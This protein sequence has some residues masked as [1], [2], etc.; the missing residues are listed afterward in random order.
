MIKITDGLVWYYAYGS[1]RKH[2]CFGVGNK[3]HFKDWRLTAINKILVGLLK[4]FE[5]QNQAA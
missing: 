3:N 5:R 4:H 1:M 2:F